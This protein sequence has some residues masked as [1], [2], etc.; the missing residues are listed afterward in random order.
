MSEVEQ[1]IEQQMIQKADEYIDDVI[2]PEGLVTFDEPGRG[3]FFGL[4]ADEDGD[5]DLMDSGSAAFA[6]F[7]AGMGQLDMDSDAFGGMGAWA[8]WGFKR[9]K[10]RLGAFRK[11]RKKMARK[12]LNKVAGVHKK[13]MRNT[14]NLVRKARNVRNPFRRG[15][16]LNKAK[17]TAQKAGQVKRAGMKLAKEAAAPRISRAEARLA[18]RPV[19][20]QMSKSVSSP[21]RGV[22]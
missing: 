15:Q 19:V 2:P 18:M 4:G 9:F 5:V 6:G 3:G 14:K 8:P 13:L 12:T 1:A 22:M 21:A 16:M 10:K 7:F 17:A 11:A 20:K